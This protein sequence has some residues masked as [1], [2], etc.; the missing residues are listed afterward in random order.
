MKTIKNEQDKKLAKEL[1]EVI[2]QR[3][4]IEKRERYI[5]GYFKLMLPQELVKVGNY[6]IT[7]TDQERASIDK[8]KLI[9]DKGED[10]VSDYTSVTVF[11]KLDIKKAA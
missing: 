11:K 1:Y 4:K 3:K 10:F 7:L 6:V 9:A 8:N 5:K 2:E